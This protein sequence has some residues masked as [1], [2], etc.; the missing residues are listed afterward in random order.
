MKKILFPTDFSEAAD[1][2]FLYA[3]NIARSM[4]AEVVVY[5]AYQLPDIHSVHLPSTMQDIYE[6]MDREESQ[7]FRFKIASYRKVADEAGFA[8]VVLSEELQQGETLSSILQTASATKADMIVMGTTGAGMLKEIFLGSVA[9]EVMENASCPVL[10]IPGAAS[11]KGGIGKIAVTTNYLEEDALL[12]KKVMAWA[13][14]FNAKVYCVH[15]DSAHTESIIHKMDA[16][17]VAVPVDESVECV[18]LNEFDVEKAIVHFVQ[19]NNI[20][21][22]AMLAHKRSFFK[23][24]FQY[25]LVKTMSYHTEVPILAF[26]AEILK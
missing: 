2:A 25:S 22:V 15:V 3:L 26:Q 4:S 19:E 14:L 12:L 17:R 18:V 10:A 20:D 11:Y 1:N 16:F 13:A 21:V 5:H 8:D 6:S 23:E 24:L 9:G 7:K